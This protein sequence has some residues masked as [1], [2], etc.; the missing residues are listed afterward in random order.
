[1]NN[2]CLCKYKK[3]LTLSTLYNG[4]RL[5]AN[6]PRESRT[7]LKS[8]GNK[9]C[10]LLKMIFERICN[11]LDETSQTHHNLIPKLKHVLSQINKLGSNNPEQ[12]IDIPFLDLKQIKQ[13]K[14]ND[15]DL[16]TEYCNNSVIEPIT[17]DHILDSNDK[18]TPHVSAKKTINSSCQTEQPNPN[19]FSQ[20]TDFK[21]TSLELK[22]SIFLSDNYNQINSN[23]N[24][25]ELSYLTKIKPLNP[26]SEKYLATNELNANPSLSLF[27]H[28][29]YMLTNG[30]T[31]DPFLSPFNSSG[32]MST[33]N[34]SMMQPYLDSTDINNFSNPKYLSGYASSVTNNYQFRNPSYFDYDKTFPII[35]HYYL[36]PDYKMSYSDPNK[37]YQYIV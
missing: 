28:S 11:Y 20:V 27:N 24:L 16:S 30:L 14:R 17:P 2:N 21:N 10:D 3:E 5:L 25:G 13:I 29:G 31:T 23:N 8:C 9:E 19:N 15:S 22:P 7:D 1:M 36:M 26:V 34:T 35:S 18:E 37:Y 32:Y 33:A 4:I 6:T 12:Y